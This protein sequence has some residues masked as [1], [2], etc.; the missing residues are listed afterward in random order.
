MEKN[1]KY[2]GPKLLENT[3]Q[4]GYCRILVIKNGQLFFSDA[5]NK[6]VKRTDK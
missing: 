3:C 1:E 4:I 2:F 6:L 5:D